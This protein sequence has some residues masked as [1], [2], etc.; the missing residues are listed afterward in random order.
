M[1]LTESEKFDHAARLVLE[2]VE[3]PEFS[4]VYE[5]E[6]LEGLSEEEQKEIHDL[7]FEAQVTVTFP[8]ADVEYEK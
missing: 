3:D 5:D 4:R 8:G 7:M 6:E 1:A 2:L